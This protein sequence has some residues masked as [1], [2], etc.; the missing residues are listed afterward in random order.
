VARRR[1]PPAHR[2]PQGP[3]CGHYDW[4]LPHS[5]FFP[6][7]TRHIRVKLLGPA[8]VAVVAAWR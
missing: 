1:Q 2:Y 3:L 6:D 5:V 8:T 4:Q 7:T